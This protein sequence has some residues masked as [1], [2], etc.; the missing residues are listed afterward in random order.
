MLVEAV[1]FISAAVFMLRSGRAFLVR[2]VGLTI[3]CVTLVTAMTAGQ[4]LNAG[5]MTYPFD[6]WRMYTTTRAPEYFYQFIVTTADG[7][8]VD[9]PFQI[10]TPWSPGPLSGYSMLAPVT[11]RLVQALN[12]CRCYADDPAVDSYIAALARVHERSTGIR[13]TEFRI[14]R[15]PERLACRPLVAEMTHVYRWRADLDAQ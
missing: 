14:S 11:W 5:R 12:A 1:V 8:T 13:L 10:L 4:L 2:S 9:Y 15:A 6:S 7:G 3:G